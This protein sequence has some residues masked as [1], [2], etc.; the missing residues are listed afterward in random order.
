MQLTTIKAKMEQL[1]HNLPEKA[2]IEEA[3]EKLYLLEVNIF[4]ICRFFNVI[5]KEWYF[6]KFLNELYEA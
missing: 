1:I 6:Q 5:F 3:M 4:L 2:S